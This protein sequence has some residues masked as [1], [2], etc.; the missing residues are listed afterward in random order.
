MSRRLVAIQIGVPLKLNSMKFVTL[1]EH[2]SWSVARWT[3]SEHAFFQELLSQEKK[4]S[5]LQNTVN[6]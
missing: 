5:V 4:F 3:L 6:F 2:F 1:G